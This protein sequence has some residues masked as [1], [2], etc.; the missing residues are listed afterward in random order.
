MAPFD[1][2]ALDGDIG[3]RLVSDT[4]VTLFS[5]KAIL[6][7]TTGWLRDHHYRLT[8]LQCATWDTEADLHRDVATAF[9]FPDYYS[10]NLDALNDCLS[11]VVDYAYGSSEDT[12][13]TVMVLHRFDHFT[14]R[15]RHG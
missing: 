3:W 8:E 13:G 7:E 5:N 1:R 2:D 11:D 9:S 10:C 12:A 14:A 15:C 4:F 6:A